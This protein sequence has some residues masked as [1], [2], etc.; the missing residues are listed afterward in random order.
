MD[1][2]PNDFIDYN[3]DLSYILMGVAYAHLFKDDVKMALPLDLLSFIMPRLEATSLP[4]WIPEWGLSDH[5]HH[6]MVLT[7]AYS[8]AKD[9][10]A[11]RSY[12]C[13][14]DDDLVRFASISQLCVIVF[15]C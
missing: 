7:T 6:P 5:D 9:S 14:L 8:D 2:I 12:V 1:S 10:Q 11:S 4:S 13:T 3:L 15:I